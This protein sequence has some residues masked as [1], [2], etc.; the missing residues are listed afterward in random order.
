MNAASK[1]ISFQDI[2][3]KRL[4]DLLALPKWVSLRF[5]ISAPGF[6]VKK[7]LHVIRAHQQ[8]SVK[9]C[10]ILSTQ[11]FTPSGRQCKSHGAKGVSLLPNRRSEQ[12]ISFVFIVFFEKQKEGYLF[13]ISEVDIVASK[14][15][16]WHIT[17]D[18][19]TE[20]KSFS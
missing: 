15:I 16:L 18:I 20:N 17:A 4:S 5:L 1:T 3:W 12:N 10:H 8:M 2:P 11:N 19:R 7:I 6:W 14:L 13:Q 9:L